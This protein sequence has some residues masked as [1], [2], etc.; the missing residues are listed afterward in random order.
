M[1]VLFAGTPD[2]AVPSLDAIIAAGHDV[3]GVLTRPSAPAGRG[4]RLVDSPVAV[5]AAEL[6]LPVF[7]PER[8][9]DDAFASTLD[10]LAPD[11][12]VVV[13]YGALLPSSV[14][15]VP[16][17]GWVNLHFSVLPRWRGAAPVQRALIAGDAEVGMTTFRIVRELDAGPI[18]ATYSA[19]LDPD[20]TAGE[21]LRTLA[22]L[23][24][25]LLVETL[26]LIE[27]GATPT[28]QSD[29]G[30]TLAPKLAAEGAQLD[31]RRDATSLHN[32]VRGHSPE[33]GAWTTHRGQ[34]LKVL[35]TAHA[36]DASLAPGELR[37]TKR[38]VYVGTAAGAL[39]LVTVQPVGRRPMAG[40]DWARGG[41]ADGLVL[42]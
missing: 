11:V 27:A 28:P 35:R 23:G 33:P 39:E 8:P 32:H 30:T 17:H 12:C 34:R 42:R 36:T 20:A 37:V 38:N 5:R 2:V 41:I 10:E 15:D 29:E 9:G 7:T 19:P 4:R 1:R 16:T 14:L 26:R 6:G 24:G 31:W 3:L 21:V 13:A 40:A 22:D 25:G 18:Y